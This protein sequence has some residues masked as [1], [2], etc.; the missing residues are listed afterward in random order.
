VFGDIAVLSG[1]ST[2]EPFPGR[3]W[4]IDLYWHFKDD[5][6]I[7]SFV[8]LL[9]AQGESVAQLDK[10]DIQDSGAGQM[11]DSYVLYAPATLPAQP[12]TIRIGL[13]QC[14]DEENTFS[15]DV[16]TTP[17]VRFDD[18]TNPDGWITLAN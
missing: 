16:R 4:E 15:C 10:L 3:V 9:N 13:W 17:T 6:V 2:H 18:Q 12:Y 8:H 7:N 5:L 14:L 1:I 11:R